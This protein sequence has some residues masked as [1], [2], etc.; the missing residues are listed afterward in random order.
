V[1]G[2]AYK[3]M[4]TAVARNAELSLPAVTNGPVGDW[5]RECGSKRRSA[6][7]LKLAHQLLLHQA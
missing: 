3:L 7:I 6:G 1:S 4:A 5:R 2:G